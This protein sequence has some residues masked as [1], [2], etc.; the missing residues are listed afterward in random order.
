[1]LLLTSVLELGT[2]TEKI[3]IKACQ[4]GISN[5]VLAR[6]LVSL[7]K[8]ISRISNEFLNEFRQF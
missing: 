4:E 3:I 5:R 2:R 8:I 6:D 1:M 7:L